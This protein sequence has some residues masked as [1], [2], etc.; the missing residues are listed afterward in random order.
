MQ[1]AP[2]SPDFLSASLPQ[3]LTLQDLAA[4]A[5]SVST[6]ATLRRA[7]LFADESGRAA[8]LPIIQ[9]LVGEVRD[10]TV[11]LGAAMQSPALVAGLGAGNGGSKWNG[12]SRAA[13]ASTV[14]ALGSVLHTP[15]RQQQLVDNAVWA[16]RGRCQR[17]VSETEAG[18][19]RCSLCLS[20]SG[21]YN[22]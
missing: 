18:M 14:T 17:W 7:A 6:A 1:T 19:A 16:L 3:D 15:G 10:L 9:C 11:A 2:T 12:L 21:E 22:V 20:S 13:V 4:A 8:W 5:S